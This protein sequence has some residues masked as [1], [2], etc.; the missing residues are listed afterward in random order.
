MTYN[1]LDEDALDARSHAA[2]RALSQMSEEE[3]R[4]LSM[5]PE[6]KKFFLEYKSTHP[7][8]P[9]GYF[10]EYQKHLQNTYNTL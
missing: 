4:M 8:K 2:A 7:K 1:E 3:R 10:K 6:E 5:T 9:W